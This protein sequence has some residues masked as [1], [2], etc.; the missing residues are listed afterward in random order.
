M[1]GT[2]NASQVGY[3]KNFQC[4]LLRNLVHSEDLLKVAVDQLKLE[5]FELDI[6]R[7]VWEALSRYFNEYKMMPTVDMLA[8]QVMKVCQNA[9]GLYRSYV[10][11]EE[12]EALSWLLHRMSAVDG[13]NPD[14]YR[15]ELGSYL[16]W[17]RTSRIIDEHRQLLKDGANPSLMLGQL[18]QVERD[19]DSAFDKEELFSFVTEKPELIIDP[20]KVV[21]VSTGS[22]K[23]DTMIDGGLAP[24]ELGQVT[25]C[26][27]VGK[28]NVLI[29]MAT[30]ATYSGIRSLF[31]TLELSG[32]AVK[33]RYIA[34]A[35]GV[36]ADTMKLPI[37]FWEQEEHL[38]LA[39]FMDPAFG[40]H[41]MCAVSDMAREPLVT[42]K[43]ETIIE[44]WKAEHRKRF[45]TD[46]DCRLVCVDW[47]DYLR[48]PA[49][50]R[51]RDMADWRVPK[52]INA[53][54][55]FIA[56]RQQ[57]ALWTANQG[58]AQA[59]G[60]SILGMDA[61]SFAFHT[62][63]AL[64]IGIGVG[65]SPEY[66]V[67]EDNLDELQ[68]LKDMK[69][70]FTINKNRNGSIGCCELYRAPTLR[71]FDNQ[72]AYNSYRRAMQEINFDLGHAFNINKPKQV[73][74]QAMGTEAIADV[75]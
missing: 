57:V 5:D 41:N 6:C 1:D 40:A 68:K 67:T 14:Y 48:L 16:K 64:D 71:L 30:A 20:S 31:V 56:Q 32:A 26:P 24:G 25:A 13:L 63:D 4:E 39:V 2:L 74:V 66:R 42:S 65:P 15:N 27:G 19:L 22:S 36:L 52:E 44:E 28:T 49:H 51:S 11:P 55:R 18:A 10:S 47:Q 46:E 75:G 12:H 58:K 35:S 9:D 34:M 54:L 72:A 33:H 17:I 43:L 50:K 45:G 70:V 69:L 8:M 62:N 7:V 21:R 29:N 61:T 3:F 60:R 23:L 38:K 73:A 53:E 59:V 37:D